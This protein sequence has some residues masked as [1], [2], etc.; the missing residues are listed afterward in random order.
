MLCHLPNGLS[1]RGK[2]Q[3]GFHGIPYFIPRRRYYL[4]PPKINRLG[5]RG[6]AWVTVSRELEGSGSCSIL[7]RRNF[8]KPEAGNLKQKE[9]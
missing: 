8:D 1:N 2:S 3:I 9:M 7:P 5:K 6:R 4:S